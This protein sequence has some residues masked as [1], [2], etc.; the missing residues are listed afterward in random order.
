M[1]GYRYVDLG[2]SEPPFYLDR[3]CSGDHCAAVTLYA[4][5]EFTSASDAE[6]GAPAVAQVRVSVGMNTLRWERL[7]DLDVCSGVW[8]ELLATALVKVAELDLLDRTSCP[9]C[10]PVS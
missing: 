10:G 7:L 9:V 2:G 8:A 1:R 6:P 4:P 5:L 3:I